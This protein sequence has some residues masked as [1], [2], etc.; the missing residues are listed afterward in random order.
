MRIQDHIP[1][2]QAGPLEAPTPT[3]PETSLD[4]KRWC[5]CTFGT[6]R[7]NGTAPWRIH[8]TLQGL[9][10]IIQLAFIWFVPGSPR[11]LVSKASKEEALAMRVKYHG[12]GTYCQDQRE[13]AR[14]IM[15]SVTRPMMRQVAMDAYDEERKLQ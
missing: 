9:H 6:F 12:E 11:W 13:V 2:A 15:R 4:T 10:S 7:I 14:T 3:M 8:S 5:W 1:H